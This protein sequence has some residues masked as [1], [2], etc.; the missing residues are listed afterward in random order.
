M[1]HFAKRKQRKN[2]TEHENIST[3][4]KQS[5]NKNNNAK[6][7]KHT[8]L[9]R[10]LHGYM[11]TYIHFHTHAYLLAMFTT[12]ILH[13]HTHIKMHTHTHPPAYTDMHTH[14]AL[15]TQFRYNGVL[16]PTR[17]NGKAVSYVKIVPAR[18]PGATSMQFYHRSTRLSNASCRNYVNLA[19]LEY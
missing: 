3:H 8:H 13:I 5:K 12:H 4:T 6:H 14:S 11:H 16:C 18:L 2:N 19:Q 1:S 10:R 15:V 9:Y 7:E 17:C